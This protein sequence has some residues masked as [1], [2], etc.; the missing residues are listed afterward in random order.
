MQI[1][2]EKHTP[3]ISGFHSK[4]GATGTFGGNSPVDKN[5][6]DC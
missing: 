1:N 5:N 4:N 2:G 6:A 3:S